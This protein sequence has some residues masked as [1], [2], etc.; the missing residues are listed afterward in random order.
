MDLSLFLLTLK[1]FSQLIH[2]SDT[3]V[4]DTPG[5]QRLSRY[6]HKLVNTSADPCD[7][8]YEFACGQFIAMAKNETALAVVSVDL[9]TRQLIVNATLYGLAGVNLKNKTVPKAFK[10]ARRY[11]DACVDYDA[12]D[13]S[14]QEEV[15]NFLVQF[16]NW[17]F[18]N[19]TWESDSFDVVKLVGKLQG[20]LSLPTLV[21]LTIDV[22]K[23]QNSR[24]TLYLKEGSLIYDVIQYNETVFPEFKDQYTEVIFKALQQLT[25]NTKVTHH[26]VKSLRKIAR[27][28]VEFEADIAS[29]IIPET[30]V[31][32]DD[33]TKY[34]HPYTLS[35]LNNVYNSSS[36][37][38]RYFQ[39][40]LSNNSKHLAWLTENKIV[41]TQLPYY[42]FLAQKF[43]ST[44]R[45]VIANYLM[46]RTLAFLGPYFD[47][48]FL[49]VGLTAEERKLL[50]RR[51]LN[52]DKPKLT[53]ENADCL[54]ETMAVFEHVAGR[55]YVESRYSATK[56]RAAL[57]LTDQILKA[58]RKI[59]EDNQW[60][61]K[62]AKMR[63]FAKMD[64]LVTNIGFPEWIFN[65]TL[66]NEYYAAYRIRS[67]YSYFRSQMAFKRF[68]LDDLFELVDRHRFLMPVT[69]A[70]NAAYFPVTNALTVP[71]G[72]LE[73]PFFDP[74]YPDFYNIAVVGETMGHEIFH[75]FDNTGIKH[76]IKIKK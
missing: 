9:A 51:K 26:N 45:E 70:N 11:F 16:E 56:H 1:L 34:Y 22:D 38:N 66:L 12:S 33:I 64:N 24:Y 59:F 50:R 15:V 55:I 57:N 20:E 30:Q 36:V 60:L 32:E 23:L 68:S 62:E 52:S 73:Y 43:R 75:G 39:A 54:E 3:K 27:E 29:N 61:S 13:D 65:D 25:I 44:P 67:N 53:V 71:A 69:Q 6:L 47:Q 4:C 40:A 19:K 17:P 37:W 41:V 31:N 14:A 72:Q 21:S 18:L 5:C 8:F 63:I 28:I 58:S 49:Q 10:Y 46:W 42:Q 74:E 2:S 76:V 48:N 7:N 35:E